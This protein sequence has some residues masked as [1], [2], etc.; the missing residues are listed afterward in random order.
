MLDPRISII[1]SISLLAI[2]GLYK[3][4]KRWNRAMLQLI[5]VMFFKTDCIKKRSVCF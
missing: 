3:L 1:L 2:F 5:F 4:F